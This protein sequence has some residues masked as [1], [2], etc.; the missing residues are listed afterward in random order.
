MHILVESN[1]IYK[2][3]YQRALVLRV[4]DR[5]ARSSVL[6]RA[7]TMCG[8]IAIRDAVHNVIIAVY[9][10]DAGRTAAIISA[11]PNGNFEIQLPPI[12]WAGE[13]QQLSSAG[14]VEVSPWV[15]FLIG[16]Y[17]FDEQDEW[18]VNLANCL[19]KLGTLA[20]IL[21]MPME[22]IAA[23]KLESPS[24]GVLFAVP[25]QDLDPQAMHD[26]T[27]DVR[28]ILAALA[29]ASFDVGD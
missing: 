29:W 3:K 15:V 28:P 25:N 1:E 20:K 18:V 13:A 2:Y 9:Q 6:V 16:N 10:N 8:S 23:L 14:D 27:V 21:D 4:I 22:K 26:T 24:G 19:M 5:I 12:S 11:L 7:I 17:L